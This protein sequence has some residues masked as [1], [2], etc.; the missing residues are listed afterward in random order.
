MKKTIHAT[1]FHVASLKS[2]EYHVHCLPGNKSWCRY[3]SDK[4][5][6]LSTYK[7]GPDNKLGLPLEVLKHVKANLFWAD[8]EMQI[9]ILALISKLFFI[10]RFFV[11]NVTYSSFIRCS[12]FNFFYS[13]GKF[14]KKTDRPK[15]EKNLRKMK[16]LMVHTLRKTAYGNNW[17]GYKI[18]R[19]LKQNRTHLQQLKE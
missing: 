5:T 10:E 14:L 4:A 7:L 11:Y 16:K 19:N 18:K 6:G 3:Q 1:L 8:P 17:K 13:I 2:S 9:F 15:E 12:I